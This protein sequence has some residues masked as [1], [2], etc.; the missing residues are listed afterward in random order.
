MLLK[1]DEMYIFV[2]HVL[3]QLKSKVKFYFVGT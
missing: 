1:L 3:I 2:K